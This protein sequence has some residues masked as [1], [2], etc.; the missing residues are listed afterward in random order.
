MQLN[1]LKDLY[2]DHLR[3]LYAEEKHSL[4]VLP[5][6]ADAASSPKLAAAFRKHLVQTRRHVARLEQL[7]RRLSETP[8]GRNVEV[9]E[10]LEGLLGECLSVI[11][12]E[13]E[14]YIKDTALIAAAQHLEH[15][16]IAR[17]GCLRTWARLLG[18]EEAAN[19]L[20]QTLQ[21][22]KQANAHLTW[23]GY[24]LNVEAAAVSL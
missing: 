23:I 8:P 13:A 7:F 10:D 4:N 16:E 14:A 3:E 12:A 19:L 5:K 2:V 15:D 18:D 9:L 21:E 6:M 17:Y 11:D 22:E 1:T 20:Q 24:S